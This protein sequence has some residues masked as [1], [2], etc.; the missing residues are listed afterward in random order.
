[1]TGR[2][3]RDRRVVFLGAGSAAVGAADRL[4][5]APVLDGPSEAEA[6]GHLRPVDGDGLPHAGRTDPTPE[7]RAYA[8]PAERVA[9]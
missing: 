9:D 2:R 6:R 7:Q 4:R 1:V 5:A 8:R 3:L